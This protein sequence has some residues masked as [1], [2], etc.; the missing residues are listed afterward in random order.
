MALVSTSVFIMVWAPKTV[1]CPCL[2]PLS[3]SQLHP[4]SQGGSP[5]SAS[6]YD[7]CSF[8]IT[9]SVQGP[10][11]CEILCVLFMGGVF[12]SH[13]PLAL[14]KVSPTGL[15]RQIF[16]GL[17]FLVQDPWVGCPLWGLDTLLLGENLC[18]YDYSP[19]SGSP[20]QGYGSWVSHDSTHPIH[21]VVSSL[22][23]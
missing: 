8:H 21:L 12:I 20:P 23:L 7:P 13:S 1:C 11:V 5:K 3:E 6:G 16:W 19:I 17:I 2:C 22:Y 9:A 18:N 4:A 10:I 14:L 15:Q